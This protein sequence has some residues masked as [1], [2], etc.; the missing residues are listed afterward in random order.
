[1][2]MDAFIQSTCFAAVGE[3]GA[4]SFNQLHLNQS[5]ERASLHSLRRRGFWRG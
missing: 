5:K 2:R 1:M 3:T 4:N